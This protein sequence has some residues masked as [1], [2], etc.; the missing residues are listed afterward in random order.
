MGQ[1][2][3]G[4][5]GRRKANLELNLIPI[6]DLMSVLITFLLIT[7]VWT[8][9]S[10]LQIGSSV[11]GKR[12]DTEKV[13][14]PPDAGIVLRLDIKRKSYILTVGKKK[15]F[16]A[17][18]SGKYDREGLAKKLEGVKK[19]Y[20]KKTDVALSMSDDLAYHNLINGMDVLLNSGFVQIAIA[21]GGPE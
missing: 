4:G 8:Q 20:P 3:T 5:R 16:L 1:N 9:V 21:T 17:K 13:K 11:Y 12:S 15:Y 7:A 19:R 6:I 18:V 14:P 10:M 2:E